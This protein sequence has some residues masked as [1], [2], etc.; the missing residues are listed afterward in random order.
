MRLGKDVERLRRRSHGLT[1]A[2]GFCSVEAGS[3]RPLGAEA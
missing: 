1:A 2:I 3:S